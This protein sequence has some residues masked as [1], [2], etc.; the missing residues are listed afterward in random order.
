MSDLILKQSFDNDIAVIGLACRVPGAENYNDFWELITHKKE[1]ICFF[2]RAE[3]IQS[4]IGLGLIDNPDYVPARGIL[5]DVDKFDAAFFGYTP[6]EARIMDPQHRIFLE[7]TWTALENA[8]YVAN[9]FSGHIGVFAG[10]NDSTYLL[11]HLLNN[12]QIKAEYDTQQL[13]LATSSHYLCTKVAYALGLTGPSVTVNTACSTG[14]VSIAMACDSLVRH[15]CDMAL[16]GGIT[17]VTPQ[18]SGYLYQEFGILSPD[19]HCRVFDE[20]TH[21]T[22]LSNGCGVVVLRRLS[23][24]LRDNDNIIAVIKGWAINNDG[25]TKVGF[26]AP[27][28]SGQVACVQQAIARAEIAPS[29]VEYIEAHG[30]GTLLGDP[31]EISAL[32]YSIHSINAHNPYKG[33]LS[34]I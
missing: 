23:D 24:A 34:Y 22:V 10:M 1:S 7:H 30:T 12:T 31:I 27:S 8:G 29:E 6:S 15:G 18:Q 26:T 33:S 2:D 3:L 14:L 11:S 28:V 19:G 20:N 17:V 4:G 5:P 13:L 21:G 32:L 25:A 9:T 16:A